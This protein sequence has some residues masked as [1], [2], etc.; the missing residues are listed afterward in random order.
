MGFISNLFKKNSTEKKPVEQEKEKELSAEE[1]KKI[2]EEDKERAREESISLAY[3]HMIDTMEKSPIYKLY[4]SYAE[5][6]GQEKISTVLFL[7]KMLEETNK[8]GVFMSTLDKKSFLY[9]C[10]NNLNKTYKGY[11]DEK[12]AA[13]ENYKEGIRANAR[14]QAEEKGEDV[15]AAVKKATENL[16][17]PFNSYDAMVQCFT[18][19]DDMV[20]YCFLTPRIAQG[21]EFNKDLIKKAFETSKIN[22]NI[23]QEKY[24][25]LVENPVYFKFI[26]IAKGI[27]PVDGV[28]GSIEALYDRDSAPKFKE[29]DKGQVDY[30]NLGTFS[31][32][33]KDDVICK[34]TK[35]VKGENGVT[36]KGKTLKAYNGKEPNIPKGEGTALS[37]DGLSLLATTDGYIAFEH[38]NFVVKQKMFIN[39][40]I[41][42]STGNVIFNGDIEIKGDVQTGFTVD[43]TGNI[44]VFGVVEGAI[45]KAGGDISLKSGVSGNGVAELTSGG[46]IK[47]LFLENC[48]V[49]SNGGIY[50]ES[51]IQSEVYSD[52]IIDCLRGKGAIIG[53]S[54]NAREGVDANV[55][56]SKSG[57]LTT[58]NLGKSHNATNKQEEVEQELEIAKQLYDRISKNVAFLESMPEIPND[59]KQLYEQLKDQ[60]IAYAKKVQEGTVE[61]A[62]II[63]TRTHYDN[64]W[65]KSGVLYEPTKLF[66][67]HAQKNLPFGNAVCYKYSSEEKDI[68]I[69]PYQ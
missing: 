60:E 59:K 17:N 50:T 3:S 37:E 32:I 2:D 44:K 23:D 10:I 8:S 11:A 35:A 56:G 66:I 20:A 5:D 7:D 38:G 45:L 19:D 63:A 24:D 53:G 12:N 14:K 29:N 34:I 18:T 25:S 57:K 16:A 43:V 68:V 9:T 13:F 48:L 41:D 1:Q 69:A 21:E 27:K 31:P 47:S 64:C 65:L 67:G 22:T 39:G 52:T 28:D 42:A 40:N 6:S 4:C 61:L 15:D 55:I 51:I 33:K 58:I 54:I 46:V 62:E 26:R 36:V 30:K 49:K